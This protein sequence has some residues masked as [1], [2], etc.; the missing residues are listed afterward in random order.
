MRNRCCRRHVGYPEKNPHMGHRELHGHREPR[1][2]RPCSAK[3]AC[4]VCRA[5][6]REISFLFGGWSY[7]QADLPPISR[8]TATPE[9]S[10]RPPG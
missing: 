9:I 10:V 3:A 7:P 6:R 1:S 8:V 4:T 5:S 2:N